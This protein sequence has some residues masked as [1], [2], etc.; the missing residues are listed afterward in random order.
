MGRDWLG[1]RSTVVDCVSRPFRLL[2]PG[3]VTLEELNTVCPVAVD[4]G[5]YG[6]LKQGETPRSPGM[7]Y[8]HYAPNAQVFLI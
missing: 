3:G 7:K 8:R 6:E 5:V 2:R 4:P 1:V